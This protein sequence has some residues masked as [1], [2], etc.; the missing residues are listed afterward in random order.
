MNRR[1][2]LQKLGIVAGAPLLGGVP[3]ETLVRVAQAARATARTGQVL[4]PRQAAVVTELAEIIIPAT[5]TPGAT[6]ADVTGFIDTLLD[7]WMN[8]DER[9]VFSGGLATLEQHCIDSF[10]TGFVDAAPA[11][12]ATLVQQMDDEV[13]DLLE[14]DR[15]GDGSAQVTG[16]FFYQMKRLTMLGYFTS[17]VGMVQTLHYDP[18]PGRWDPCAPLAPGR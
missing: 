11:D 5:D 2:A 16:H 3:Y 13:G 12:R 18:F 14:A 15:S 1:I 4:N 10:G 7:G 17:E 6:D 8:R 9:D